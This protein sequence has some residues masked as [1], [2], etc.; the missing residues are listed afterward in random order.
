MISVVIPTLDDE[1]AL[2]LSL[3]PLVTAAAEGA[4]RDVIVVD[5]GS[6]DA[7]HDV[8]E[9]VGGVFLKGE[10]SRGQRLAAGACRAKG[11]WLLFLSPG[12][13]LETGWHRE[14]CNVIETL[15]RKGTA[16]TRALIFRHAIDD[17]EGTARLR[18]MLARIT[19]TITGVPRF[20]QGLL[21]HRAHY[22]RLGGFRSLPAME[23]ADMARRI[24]RL[25]TVTLR[26]RAFA[27]AERKPRTAKDVFSTGLLFLRIPPKL[28][29]RLHG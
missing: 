1:R 6:R 13:V 9:A 28:I 20:E 18:E 7:T 8:V 3:T 11:P 16:Q 4:V 25:Q 12:V 5:G 15:E 29:A 10:R 14:A 21:I 26:S 19:A 24:G 22:E 27:P 2:V 17:I 23:A